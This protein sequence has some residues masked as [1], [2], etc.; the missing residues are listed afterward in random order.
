MV[1]KMNTV[2]HRGFGDNKVKRREN[3]LYMEDLFSGRAYHFY[4]IHNER[5]YLKRKAGDKFRAV[6]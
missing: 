2:P 5:I 3:V 4:G 6:N 1:K